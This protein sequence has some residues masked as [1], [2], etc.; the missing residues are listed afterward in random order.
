VADKGVGLPDG[1]DWPT[2][3]GL[4]LR[5]ARMLGQHQLQGS[6]ALDRIGGTRFSLRFEAQQRNRSA[7]HDQRNDPDRRG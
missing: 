5:L 3:P 7:H 4:G 2:T 6:F 1:L